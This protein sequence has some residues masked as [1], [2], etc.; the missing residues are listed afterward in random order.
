MNTASKIIK[1]SS[2]LIIA[3]II[4]NLM[5]FILTLFTAR[6]LGTYN[7]GIISSAISIV[8]ILTVFT[9]LGLATYA[10]R[11]VSRNTS[12]TSKYFGTVLFFR[13]IFSLIVFIFYIIFIL[14]SNFNYE[15]TLVMILF[16]IY[17][18]ISS[19][20][21]CYNSLFQSN[22]Q[23]QYQTIGTVVYSVS[24]LLII[25]LIIFYNGNVISVAAGYPIAMFLSFI[26]TTYAAIK[27][28]PKFKVSLEKSFIKELFVKGIPFGVSAAF[29][30]IYFWIAQIILTYM[31]NS[32]SVGLF[33]SSQKLL[34]I[35]AAILTLF[36]NVI[37]PVMSRLFT[38]DKK[39][40]KHLYHKVM[41]YALIMGIGMAIIVSFYS[42]DI[43]YIIYGSE[44]VVGSG[45]LTIL[46]WAGMFMFLSNISSTM[47]GAINKQVT[48]TKITGVGA[49][50]SV[51]LNII[52]I[53]K[54]SYIGASISTVLTEF[55]IVVLMLYALSKTEFKLSLKKS[56]I[57]IIQVIISS[58]FM[59]VVIV[60]FNFPFIIG[61]LIGLLVY[62]IALFITRAIDSEDRDIIYNFIEEIINK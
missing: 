6:Y 4:N 26:Y 18:V 25:L 58:I 27:H 24:V 42:A 38:T 8:G 57:P 33:S 46:I 37:F 48:V 31:S 28:Y 52:M 7:Y 2:L 45:A 61:V 55:L 54:Y 34:L 41:K 39:Q 47:L 56:I 10:I 5:T 9:D 59:T 14:N 1:N 43:I 53:N 22:E 44:Y 3:T 23:V 19:L 29:T 51:I 32:T 21:Y 62:I 49:L 40:L 60:I 50:F 30:S 20:T 17:M 12:L 11:E 16:G 13:V 15:T 35:V 36:F